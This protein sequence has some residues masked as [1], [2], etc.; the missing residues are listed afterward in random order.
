M[1]GIDIFNEKHSEA[2]LQKLFDKGQTS[3]ND[4]IVFQMNR[5]IEISTAGPPSPYIVHEDGPKDIVIVP[6]F[7]NVSKLIEKINRL[8]DFSRGTGIKADQQEEVAKLI[9]E[10]NKMKFNMSHLESITEKPLIKGQMNARRILPLV[11]IDGIFYLTNK[12][13]YFQTVHSVATKPAKIIHMEDVT[14]IFR[15]RYELKQVCIAIMKSI[16]CRFIGRHGNLYKEKVIFLC[17]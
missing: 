3:K 13:L 5:V 8:V 15:R 4:S 1:P 16:L 11:S 12:N 7:E 6:A 10:D 14:N 17:L 9:L 2:S